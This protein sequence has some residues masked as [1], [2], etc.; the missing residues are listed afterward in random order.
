MYE[1]IDRYIDRLMTSSPEMP[2][3]NIESIKQGKKPGWNYIDGCM[4]TSLMEMY[5]T[6]G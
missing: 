6:T 5:F 2:L 1:I 3:W 4:T